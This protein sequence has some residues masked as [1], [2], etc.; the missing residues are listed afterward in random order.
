MTTKSHTELAAQICQ[1]VAELPDRNSHEDWP[2]AMLV[3]HDELRAIV[4]AA[5]ESPERVQVEAVLV[6]LSEGGGGLK[7]LRNYVRFLVKRVE[8]RYWGNE[9]RMVIY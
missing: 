6:P 5:L 2:E 4:L 9:I 3:T 7:I 8:I 1:E